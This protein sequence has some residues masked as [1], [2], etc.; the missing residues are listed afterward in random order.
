MNEENLSFEKALEELQ[1]MADQIKSPGLNLEESI[2]CYEK[3]MEYYKACDR[4]LKETQQKIQ[5]V[6]VE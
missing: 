6:E 4:I 2:R 3:G 5:T 1:N